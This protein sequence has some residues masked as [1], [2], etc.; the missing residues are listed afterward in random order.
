VL[1]FGI[2]QSFAITRSHYDNIDL[3]AM[4]Q[5]YAPGYTDTQ[6]DEIKKTAASLS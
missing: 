3:V 2:H 5:G 6:L 1:R 4:S